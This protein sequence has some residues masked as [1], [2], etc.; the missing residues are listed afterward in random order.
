VNILV[1]ACLLGCKCRYDGDD[2][3]VEVVAALEKNHRL[4][5]IC[6][7]EMGGL[8]TPR[9]PAEIQGNRVINKAG[10]DVTEEFQK[11]AKLAL[12]IA[13]RE[14]CRLAILKER[15]P[16]CGYKQVYDGTFSKTLIDG[17]G[18]TAELLMQYGIGVIGESEVEKWLEN[19]KGVSENR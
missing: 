6:P 13:L 10:A 5:P 12:D 14:G 16:S 1:S 17:P 7:E 18:V 11:G 3:W 19:Q 15:S 4:V 8:P 9:L 2:N